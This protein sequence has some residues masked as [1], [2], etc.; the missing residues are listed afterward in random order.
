MLL[1]NACC[2]ARV[3]LRVHTAR[4]VVIRGDTSI[5]SSTPHILLSFVYQV[6]VTFLLLPS[7]THLPAVTTLDP[8]SIL[9]GYLGSVCYQCGSLSVR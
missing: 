6:A 2:L 1:D 9:E 8:E 5:L 7:P 4:A 3:R